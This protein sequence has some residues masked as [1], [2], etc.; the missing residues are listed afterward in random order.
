MGIKLL[1]FYKKPIALLHKQDGFTL[2]ELLIALAIFAVIAVLAYGG[3]SVVL[4]VRAQTDLQ[5]KTLAQ[6]Q[7]ALSLLARDVE[8]AVNR[9]IRNKYGDTESA[10]I[11]EPTFIEFTRAG[12]RNP[13]QST[14]STLQRVRYFWHEQQLW[15]SYWLVLD[16][17]QDSQAETGVL[18]TDIT[19]LQIRFLDNRL[20]WHEQWPP[21][22]QAVVTQV[23]NGEKL[24]PLALKAIELV[25]TVK[26]WG[27]LTRLLRVATI[28]GQTQTKQDVQ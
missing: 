27:K 20:Q 7:L 11:G 28:A 3:L 21:D 16:Q 22:A 9:P 8:Q 26:S 24:D 14:R 6:L 17:A 12:W 18:L 13:T 2:L 10:F 4:D 1:Q 19:N 15:R 25:L 23:E 5:A